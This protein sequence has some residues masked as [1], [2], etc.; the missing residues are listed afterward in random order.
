MEHLIAPFQTTVLVTVPPYAKQAGVNH[1]NASRFARTPGINP[2]TSWVTRLDLSPTGCDSGLPTTAKET[3][4]TP[5][6][7]MMIF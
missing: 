3:L 2:G 1:V 4:P 5:T 6:H 7:L